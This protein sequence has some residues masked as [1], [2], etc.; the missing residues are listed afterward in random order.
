MSGKQIYFAIDFLA[1]VAEEG[2]GW[3]SVDL[4]FPVCAVCGRRRLPFMNRYHVRDDDVV[5]VDAGMWG[6]VDH[7]L[8]ECAGIMLAREDVANALTES[9]L[10]GFEIRKASVS[11][12][13][14]ELRETS[15]P[16]YHWVVVTGRCDI[17]PIWERVV[18]SCDSCGAVLTERV[19][20]TTRS[21]ALQATD[22]HGVDVCRTRE[23]SAGILVSARLRDFL[24]RQ[25]PRVAEIANF[26]PV[27]F[28]EREADAV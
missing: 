9:G 18:G 2:D 27:A 19:Y 14:N 10:T 8:L 13:D 7:P 28:V 26:M 22:P 12:L 20:K 1:A 6:Y 25:D 5:R 21:W 11:R 24:V 4:S 23:A 17:T 15:L 16:E 3:Q